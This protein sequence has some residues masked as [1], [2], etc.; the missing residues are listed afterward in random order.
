M[1]YASLEDLLAA[2]F[3]IIFNHHA[4]IQK[5]CVTVTQANIIL[6]PA[7]IACKANRFRSGK[8]EVPDEVSLQSLKCMALIGVNPHE[9]RRKQPLFLNITVRR[10]AQR[11]PGEY[12]PFCDLSDFICRHSESSNFATLEAFALST[13]R[14]VL[15]FTNGLDDEVTVEIAKPM[16][17]PLAKSAAIS[18]TRK[19]EDFSPSSIPPPNLDLV[20]IGNSSLLGSSGKVSTIAGVSQPDSGL[21]TV[22]IALG[23]NLGDRFANIETALRL[24]EAPKTILEGLDDDAEVFVVNTSFMY[25][26][27]P[28]YV[29]DQPHF[30]NCACMVETNLKPVV[31]LSLLKRI[32]D[33]V[34]R[35]PTIRNGPRAVDLDILTYDREIIDTRP[36]SKRNGLENLTGELVVPHP[37]LAEREFVLRPL[38]D[39][40]PDLVHPVYRKT[41]RALLDDLLSNQQDNELPMRKVLPF[42]KY[43]F[44]CGPTTHGISPVPS[45]AKYWTVASTNSKGRPGPHKTHVMATLNATP[46]SF[47]DG[48]IHNTLPAAIEY[49]TTSVRC[50][51]DIIDIGG[52]ST[53]PQAG[54]VSEVEE[55]NRVVPIISAIRAQENEDVWD[56]LI[57]VDTFRWQ[58]A[59]TAVLAGANCINDVYAFTGPDY[60]LGQA[61]TEHLLKMRDVAR[62]LCVPVVL[63]HSRGDPSSNKNYD[64]YGGNL[65]KAIQAE[66]GDK[67]EAIVSGRGGVRRWSVIIDSGFGF[68]KPVDAQ[69]QLLRNIASVVADQPGNRLAGYPLLI[70]TSRKS[71]LGA[72]L[73]RPDAEGTYKGR[74]T[75]PRE[76]G[77][78]TAATVACAVQQGANVV[79]VHDVLEM[80][81]V[82]GVASAMWSRP[83]P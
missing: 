83:D 15:E 45:T 25:E 22:A 63:M 38:N 26:T 67:V 61:S 48:S 4:E 18:I 76:R 82:V 56:A 8:V 14:H 3:D 6:Q 71:F 9:R 55:T 73:E 78:A 60:P 41:I 13:A 20:S 37:R 39:M 72:L 10:P 75:S 47:S 80:R 40:I 19:I 49:A 11:K 43:P 16:A 31:L 36:E 1:Q 27:A 44:I 54:F 58:V 62:R 50:G 70:G 35:V 29:T 64:V 65:V 68:S 53:R 2:T 69:F 74:K 23:S 32:E 24:L 33:A 51:A 5:V 30:A 66:L 28:M 81:D 46:D 79:R 17:L 21:H 42:P 7:S 34:G 57:S 52:Y 12:F 59:E 77:W